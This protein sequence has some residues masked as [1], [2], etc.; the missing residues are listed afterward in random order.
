MKSGN[1]SLTVGARRCGV[2]LWL[3]LLPACA[4]PPGVTLPFDG[5]YRSAVG[6]HSVG[7]A[8]AYTGD[9][10]DLPGAVADVRYGHQVARD[11][12]V[13]VDALGGAVSSR[14]NQPSAA[15]MPSVA[16]VGGVAGGRIGA[17]IN[18]LTD[19]VAFTAGFGGGG[20]FAERSDAMPYLTG[21]VGVRG[22]IRASGL[23]EVI[24]GQSLSFTGVFPRSIDAG[25]V[26]FS[27]TE[28]GVNVLAAQPVTVGAFVSMFYG[29]GQNGGDSRPRFVPSLA[30]NY[31]FGR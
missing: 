6:T 12:A 2:A 27:S 28:L 19:Y 30:V 13:T 14:A 9:Y 15:P 7:G 11:V 20:V 4:A 8:A 17:R 26:G 24:L 25:W 18:P 1:P 5:T 23:L 31:R 16:T 10:F 29:F 22:S 21:D 3:S